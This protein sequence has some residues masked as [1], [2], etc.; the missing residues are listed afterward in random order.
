VSEAKLCSSFTAEQPR[1][2]GHAAC[3]TSGIG[4]KAGPFKDMLNRLIARL[5]DGSALA[6]NKD[7]SAFSSCA[8][9]TTYAELQRVHTAI[10][11]LNIGAD[12]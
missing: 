4:C 7:L 6:Q 10:N 8:S 12:F 3:Q 5:P 2:L 11:L 9:R 1:E